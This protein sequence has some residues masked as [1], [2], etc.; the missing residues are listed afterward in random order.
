MKKHVYS[1][2]FRLALTILLLFSLLAGAILYNGYRVINGAMVSNVKAFIQQ[3]SNMF[4]LAVAPYVVENKLDILSPYFSELIISETEFQV[5]TYAVIANESGKILIWGGDLPSPLPLADLPE[6][7]DAAIAKGVV[8]IRQGMLMQDNSVGY[9][10]FG[11]S[12][13]QFKAAA[14]QALQQGLWLVGIGLIV[15]TLV[16]LSVGL[17]F[18]RR[19]SLLIKA[20]SA[21]AQGDYQQNL[22]LVGQDEIAQLAL[23]FNMMAEAIRQRITAYE[24]SRLE[25]QLLNASLEKRVI[26]RTEELAT[27]NQTLSQTIADLKQTQ[28][29]LIRS[30]KLASLGSLVAGVAHELNTP[31][32]NALTVTTTLLERTQE[33]AVEMEQGLKRSNLVKYIELV[34]S[35]CPLVHRNLSRAAELVTSFKHV[36]VNQSS[37]QIST[38]NLLEVVNEL[39]DT[40]KHTFKNTPYTLEVDIPAHIRMRSYPG[41]LGQVITNFINNA[42]VHAFAERE[43]GKMLLTAYEDAQ[44]IV[45][46]FK[47]DGTGISP[48]NIKRIFDPFFS[49]RFGQGGSGLGLNI[50]HNIVEGLLGGQINVTSVLDEGTC[51]TVKIPA[52]IDEKVNHEPTLSTDKV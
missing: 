48:E 38:F 47:D 20:S 37:S 6:A 23:Y 21:I 29:S 27:V 41:P 43:H 14:E 28:D 33:F 1:L 32:G 11:L 13:R 35:V 22:P 44:Q 26:E 12:T 51:F 49:T 9:L 10:Q 7:Y 46:E 45:L 39:I 18:V 25:V 50:V 34:Q 24:D 3:T 15:T 4:N 17:S 42:L 40:L 19:I 5:L 31:L 16:M 30:E 8:N 2:R 36:A 52:Y